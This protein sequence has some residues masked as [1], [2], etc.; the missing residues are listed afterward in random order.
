[1]WLQ[2]AFYAA[3][4]LLTAVLIW[5]LKKKTDTIEEMKSDI[6]TLGAD[7]A[8]LQGKLNGKRLIT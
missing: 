2:I 7:V 6:K 4:D 1:M 5:H 3:S 8:Y